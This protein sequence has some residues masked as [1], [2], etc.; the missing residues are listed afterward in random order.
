M[1]QP[2]TSDTSPAQTTGT[3]FLDL[4]VSGVCWLCKLSHWLAVLWQGYTHLSA[5]KSSTQTPV[6][7]WCI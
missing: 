2:F 6:E 3:H 5:L 4:G 7:C 1:P